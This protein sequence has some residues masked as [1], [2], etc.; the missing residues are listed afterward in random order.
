MRRPMI[1]VDARSLYKFC[2]ELHAKYLLTTRA[3]KLEDGFDKSQLDA[4]GQHDFDTKLEP[5]SN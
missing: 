1:T 2:T 3:I 4:A 5:P